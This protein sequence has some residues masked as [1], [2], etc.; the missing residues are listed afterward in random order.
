MRPFGARRDAC[1]V[2][3]KRRGRRGSAASQVRS[4]GSP[5]SATTSSEWVG[6]VRRAEADAPR[7][8]AAALGAEQHEVVD[9]EEPLGLAERALG[10]LHREGVRAAAAVA[11]EVDAARGERA[12]RARDVA[13]LDAAVERPVREHDD[14]AGEAVA[15]DVGRLPDLAG[16]SG[17]AERVVQRAPVARAAAV[18]LAVR[19]DDEE[20]VRDRLERRVAAG[21]R[22]GEV[23]AVEVVLV[24]D[25]E[26]EQPLLARARRR[27]EHAPAGLSAPL[28]L[29]D[30]EQA[31]GA[32]QPR[33]ARAGGP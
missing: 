21:E 3:R 28:R 16:R 5:S 30:E 2:T 33:A 22:A 14:V 4:S 9:P 24:L 7:V 17:R 23:D 1:A 25:L 11:V 6:A 12:R 27:E 20:R 10:G 26:P 18:A 32:E 31:R 19:A 15:A 13:R 8:L 29:L